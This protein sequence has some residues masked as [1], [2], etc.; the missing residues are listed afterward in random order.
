MYKQTREELISRLE[1][2][3]NFPYEYLRNLSE[4]ELEQML[5][6]RINNK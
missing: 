1:H 4:A 5:W 6:K 3:T 2:L